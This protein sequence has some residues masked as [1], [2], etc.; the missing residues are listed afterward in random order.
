MAHELVRAFDA[1]GFPLCGTL[2]DMLDEH[3]VHQS[4][5]RGCGYAQSTRYLSTLINRPRDPLSASDLQVFADWPMADTEALACT[6]LDAGLA[7]G[8]RGLL[9]PA[10]R[11]T[12]VNAS[13]HAA[14]LNAL[15]DALAAMHE[16]L[17]FEESRVFLRLL[18]QMLSGAGDAAPDLPGMP[19]K[20][21]VGSCS[22]AES[23]FLEI[24]HGR[25]RRRGS[26][27]VIVDAQGRPLLLEKLGL[28]E[29]HSAISLGPFR[30][31]GV[32]IPPGSLC[33]IRRNP[34]AVPLRQL[35]RGTVLAA[36][37]L[38]ET[39]FLR[40]TTLA[41]SPPS[42]ARAF[43]CQLQAQVRA[44]MFSP[45]TATIVQLQELAERFAQGAVP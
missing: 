1:A 26:V 14:H 29:N 28:G 32:C 37:A 19:I 22:E 24:A 20:P 12:V 39:R 27:N 17:A 44:A 33:A 15:A 4:E 45:L 23:Y 43:S 38:E 2:V 40:L 35:R 6:L 36:S 3:F 7:T 13:A 5:R 16:N 10:T 42:R 9:D 31:F 25:I 8:W 41:I 30:L 34:D 18:A 21:E 11:G